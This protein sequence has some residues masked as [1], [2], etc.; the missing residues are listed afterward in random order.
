VEEPLLKPILIAS[1]AL[2]LAVGTSAAADYRRVE[3]TDLLRN[4]PLLFGQPVEVTGELVGMDFLGVLDSDVSRE[5]MV[6][7][8]PLDPAIGQMINQM[9]TNETKCNAL[10]R[11]RVMHVRG[12]MVSELGLEADS[13]EFMPMEPEV[14][15]R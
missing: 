15:A 5:V 9:C 11:G 1:G 14:P 3:M 12:P 4:L 7:L 2:L 6:D 10:V 8:R 13:I